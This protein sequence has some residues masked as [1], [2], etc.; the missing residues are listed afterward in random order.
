MLN[1]LPNKVWHR[2]DYCDNHRVLSDQLDCKRIGNL[3]QIHFGCSKYV[4][5]YDVDTKPRLRIHLHNCCLHLRDC[6]A[7]LR[8]YCI[9]IYINYIL[10]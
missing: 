7:N 3:D 2:H 5:L 1:Q 8:S 9:V 6:F 10:K 4:C